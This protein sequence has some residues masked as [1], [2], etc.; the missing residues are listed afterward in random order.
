MKKINGKINLY[1]IWKAIQ[2]S[3]VQPQRAQEVCRALKKLQL[4]LAVTSYASI[5]LSFNFL[6]CAP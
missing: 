2:L 3:K 4:L 1:L 5:V 6:P